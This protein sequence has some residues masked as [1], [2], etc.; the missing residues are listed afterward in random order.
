MLSQFI[1]LR[2]HSGDEGQE[3][4]DAV[5]AKG[6]SEGITTVPRVRF[7]DPDGNLLEDYELMGNVAP[8]RLLRYSLSAPSC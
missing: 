7:C 3:M 6:W 1:A 5:G 4:H 8:K 2:A